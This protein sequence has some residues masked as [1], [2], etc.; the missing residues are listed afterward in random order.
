MK[1]SIC[2]IL[3]IF[4]LTSLFACDQKVSSSENTFKQ[5]VKTALN[6]LKGDVNINTTFTLSREYENPWY[7]GENNVTRVFNFSSEF[8]FNDEK[9]YT[10]ARVNHGEVKMG[11]STLIDEG[12]YETN[13]G[14]LL[15]NYLSFDNKPQL[16][17]NISS[18]TSNRV[19]AKNEI[20]YNYF[21]DIRF[22]EL[23]VDE[24]EDKVSFVSSALCAYSNTAVNFYSSNA[25]ITFTLNEGK[26]TDFVIEYEPLE[27]KYV[28]SSDFNGEI[29]LHKLS[30][31]GKITY[32]NENT[33]ALTSKETNKIEALDNVLKKFDKNFTINYLNYSSNIGEQ[34][35]NVLYD[36]DKIVV[37]LM[38]VL[39]DN[40]ELGTLSWLDAVLC[41][42][43]E[44]GKYYIKNL[45]L[46]EDTGEYYWVTNQELVD[47]SST[48]DVSEDLLYYDEGKFD[49]HLKDIDSSLFTLK[50]GETNVYTLDSKAC[51]YFG[52][53]IVPLILNFTT[54]PM[55]SITIFVTAYTFAG[56][57]W[58]VTI[59]DENTLRFDG[60]F[61][62]SFGAGAVGNSE[63]SFVF[64]NPGTTNTDVFYS[65][66]LPSLE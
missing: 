64:T 32:S 17:Y 60:K 13:T 24:Q 26:F 62:A 47:S 28:S 12:V 56:I 37:D 29:F 42:D 14:L 50:D 27:S 20:F 53:A 39:S 36:N 61:Q 43:E 58:N 4:T 1:K 9:T 19:S 66:K 2:Y 51:K 34:G 30:A 57:E 16:E 23:V 15:D 65:D 41:K 49:L 3:S 22:D 33:I 44:K 38:N 55:A 25:K 40:G 45:S 35:L 7:A 10:F 31:T 63:W 54:I 18:S 59:V 52:Q 8:R 46:N 21:Q 6:L 11:S 48:Y 5:D